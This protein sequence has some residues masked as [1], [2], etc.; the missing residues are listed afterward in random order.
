[1]ERIWV[2][3]ALFV[4]GFKKNIEDFSPCSNQSQRLLTFIPSAISSYIASSGCHQGFECHA[5]NL[6]IFSLKP[7][8]LY[9]IQKESVWKK[10]LESF[11]ISYFKSSHLICSFLMFFSSRFFKEAVIWFFISSMN[12]GKEQFDFHNRLPLDGITF[13]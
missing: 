6:K 5:Q 12:F 8:Y 2:L 11:L 3:I 1:M 10:F 4:S 7:F 9:L 13:S